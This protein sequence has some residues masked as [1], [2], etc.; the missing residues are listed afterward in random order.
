LVDRAAFEAAF[1]QAAEDTRAFAGQFVADELPGPLR[2]DFT[3]AKRTPQA[4]GRIK[5]LGGRL[6]TPDQLQGVEL[7]RAGQYLWADGKVPAWVNLAV[8]RA[9][10]DYTYIEVTVSGVV[11]EYD[12]VVVGG[13]GPGE[14]FRIRGPILPPGWVS[15]ETSG[16]FCLGWLG[17]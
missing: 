7:R 6:L 14:P 4:D 3:A 2:F 16:R 13:L 9:D 15:V 10:Q 1:Q 11:L 8:C 5:F 12:R 17:D